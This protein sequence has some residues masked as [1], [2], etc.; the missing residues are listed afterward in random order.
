MQWFVRRLTAVIAVAFAAMAVGV[1]A[2]PAIGSA[3]CDRNMSWNRTTE[4][5]KPPPPPPDW[6]AAPPEYAPPFAAQ[7]VPPPPPPRP[8]WSPN[9]PMWNAGF[10][11]WGTY[12]TGTWVPY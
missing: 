7:D 12:F 9:E 5:C 2:T 11:Q 10:H 3:E 4:E 1:I 8:S 6:Y